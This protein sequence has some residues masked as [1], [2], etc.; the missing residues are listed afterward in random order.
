VPAWVFAA[1]TPTP[2]PSGVTPSYD[3]IGPG[4]TAFVVLFLLA[5]ATVV[6]IRSMVGHLRKVR[7]SSPP[8]DT[9]PA[10]PNSPRPPEG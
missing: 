3:T 9:P 5:L 4:F 10:P 7:Y 6:L 2:T 8:G 1:A